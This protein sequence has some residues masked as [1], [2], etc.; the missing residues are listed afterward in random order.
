MFND[1]QFSEENRLPNTF[2]EWPIYLILT[3][4]IL[5]SWLGLYIKSSYY[6]R[7]RK[8]QN[9]F[10]S[11]S[12]SE[13]K[14]RFSC[15]FA[16]ISAKNRS[17]LILLLFIA[18][19]FL[20]LGL[21]LFPLLLLLFSTYNTM[22]DPITKSPIA[23]DKASPTWGALIAFFCISITVFYFVL[24][25]SMKASWK[26]RQTQDLRKTMIEE[27]HIEESSDIVEHEPILLNN[28][29]I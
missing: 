25:A 28:D 12:D 24:I 18:S 7:F 8:L 10:S 13:T 14:S 15:D 29:M 4:L 11:S 5:A 20:S 1:F 3:L 17:S 6:G 27:Y 16:A 22:T 21:L 23:W 9:W 2:D 19:F 26:G